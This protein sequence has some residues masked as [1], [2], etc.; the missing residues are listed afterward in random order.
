ML[1]THRTMPPALDLNAEFNESEF[2][3]T[4]VLGSSSCDSESWAGLGVSDERTGVGE[5][6]RL[7]EEKGTEGRSAFER[8]TRRSRNAKSTGDSRRN[9][10]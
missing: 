9:R 8:E 2:L 7:G 3:E 6:E 10:S 4:R 5:E 1:L